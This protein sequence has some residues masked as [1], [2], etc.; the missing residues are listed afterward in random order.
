MLMMIMISVPGQRK[1]LPGSAAAVK[2][3]RSGPESGNERH[4]ER[5]PECTAAGRRRVQSV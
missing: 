4:A 5:I 2:R 1:E 3:T